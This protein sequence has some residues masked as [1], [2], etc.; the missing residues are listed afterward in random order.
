MSRYFRGMFSLQ[1]AQKLGI[2]KVRVQVKGIGKGRQV[3]ASVPQQCVHCVQSLVTSALSVTYTC[4]HAHTHTHTH[5]HTHHTRTHTTTT[6]IHTTTTPYTHTHTHTHTP[7]HTHTH[8]HTHH[9]I[10][11]C[12]HIP[13]HTHTGVNQR[14]GGW[15][16]GYCVNHRCH[17]SAS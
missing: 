17:S 7:H 16:T 14:D 4:T 13:H 1:K 10:H 8:T 6:T 3:C 9:T 11:T 12:A 15:W 2:Q 5:T